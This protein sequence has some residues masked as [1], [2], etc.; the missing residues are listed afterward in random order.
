MRS[1]QEH[2]SGEATNRAF[3]VLYDELHA[4]AARYLRHERASHTLQPT[5]LVNEAYVRLAESKA[6]PSASREQFL[7]IAASVMR[8]VLVD[9]ARNRDAA[10]RGGGLERVTIG[11]CCEDLRSGERPIDVLALDEALTRLEALHPRQARLV[12]FRLFGGLTIDQAAPLIDVASSTAFK[13]W[14]MA[15]TWLSRELSR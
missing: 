12:Q 13:D 1:E 11:S 15:R 8:H 10:K 3:G 5:A 9:H 2:R 6:L 7:G 4:L 14:E